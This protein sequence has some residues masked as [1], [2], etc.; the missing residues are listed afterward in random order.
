MSNVKQFFD[1]IDPADVIRYKTYW[2]SIKPV[3]NDEK[4]LRWIFAY[5]SIHTTWTSNV[6]GYEALK[7][8][9]DWINDKALLKQ[10][11]IDAR[12]GLFNMRTEYI[13]DFAKKFWENPSMFEHQEGESCA[14][15]RN[16]L[17]DNLR[18]I[19]MTKVSFTIE[20]LIPNECEV[21]CLDTHMMQFFN[22]PKNMKFES[23]KGRDIYVATE[24][25]WLD[26]CREKDIPSTIARAI[27]W[28]RNQGKEDSRYWTYVLEG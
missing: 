25:A 20:M 18:G 13:W 7:D 21:F 3:T 27:Y 10:K 6:K 16:R 9:S 19:G 17:V 15:C 4:F 12:V 11:I 1:S 8:Y 22:V 23:G 26:M 24:N 14:D 5:M 2:E 28:D